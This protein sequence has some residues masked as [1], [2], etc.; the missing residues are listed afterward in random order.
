MTQH[1]R[2]STNQG[3]GFPDPPSSSCPKAYVTLEEAAILRKLRAVR[4]RALALRA[5]V[6]EA[7]GDAQRAKL[8]QE[9]ARLREQRRNLLT[10]QD[11]AWTRKMIM[12]GHLPPDAEHQC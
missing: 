11:A 5:Q 8:E 9:L 2:R 10:Q 6:Q 3:S 7:T 4:D 12:L 1:H